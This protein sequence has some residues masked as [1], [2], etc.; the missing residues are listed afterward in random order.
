MILAKRPSWRERKV[1]SD[2]AEVGRIW[3]SAWRRKRAANRAALAQR[4]STRCALYAPPVVHARH[5]R[6]SAAGTMQV[7]V[8]ETGKAPRRAGGISGGSAPMRDVPSGGSRT[9]SW[10]GGWA[11][12]LARRGNGGRHIPGK[13]KHCDAQ[14]M[15]TSLYAQIRGP[16]LPFWGASRGG[17]ATDEIHL[18]LVSAKFDRNPSSPGPA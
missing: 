11:V 2:R 15:L 18:T 9:H 3:G 1:V 12:L 7:G 17:R 13:A 8:R 6:R 5:A 16:P 4:S 14:G 10:L